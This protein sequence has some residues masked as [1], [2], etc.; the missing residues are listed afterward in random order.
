MTMSHDNFGNAEDQLA[1]D[2]LRFERARER[3]RGIM[4]E[5]L[6]HAPLRLF[7]TAD[8]QHLPKRLLGR[9]VTELLM[10]MTAAEILEI[11]GVGPTR[12]R[13]LLDVIERAILHM[14]TSRESRSVHQ[15]PRLIAEPT[16]AMATPVQPEAAPGDNRSTWQTY[17]DLI[18][19]HRLDH[20]PIG[21][22][23]DS[24][25]DLPR[26]LWDKPL[27]AFHD[28]IPLGP[29]TR[30]KVELVVT[31]LARFLESLDPNSFA[32]LPAL[33]VMRQLAAWIERAA[34]QPEPPTR[35]E[36]VGG[37]CEPLLSQI[38]VDSSADVS[39]MCALKLG[40][41]AEPETLESIG[42]RFGVTRERIRQHLATVCD[43][44][45]IRWPDGPSQL[46]RL[47]D[48]LNAPSTRSDV[49]ELV[50]RVAKE[51]FDTA[52]ISH[53]KVAETVTEAWRA[54]GRQRLTPMTVEEMQEWSARTLPEIEHDG[55]V[56]LIQSRFPTCERDRKPVW[57]SDSD[58]D[59]VLWVL[60]M[61]AEPA[62]VTDILGELHTA[63]A[64]LHDGATVEQLLATAHEAKTPRS[65]AGKMG[66]DPRFV[67]IED[68]QW[69]PAEACGF[70][71]TNGVWSIRLSTPPHIT[72]P[73]DS[74]PIS[75]V[76]TFL[77]NG[78]LQ[79]GIVDATSAGVHRFINEI[80][81]QL[82]G[83][84][85]PP[86]ITPYVL[87]DMLVVHGDGVIRHMRRR[88]LQWEA[89]APGLQA[90]G[91][92]RWVG[93]V[94]T[95]VGK[96]IVL[97]E[98]DTGLRTYYQ[99]YADYVIQQIHYHHYSI[100]DDAG[101]SD[102]RV[103]FITHLGAGIPIIVAPIDWQ[104]DGDANPPNVSPGVMEVV[105]QLRAKIAAGEMNPSALRLTSWLA[106]LVHRDA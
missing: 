41:R 34:R 70:F 55:A 101:G 63:H 12:L 91:K 94:V 31:Q 84:S 76:V 21:M 54:A 35:V 27:S 22:F 57:F 47:L 73:L 3:L 72:R 68:K 45:R 69:L 24:I 104:L 48:V 58:T 97:A 49:Q 50:G 29:V 64:V 40:I 37:F 17:F 82:F 53:A 79:L 46:K 81:G 25:R 77:V 1:F 105:L 32:T 65:L 30:Q 38:E 96:P 87:A 67:E 4:G 56:E 93:H 85:L 89:A 92:R 15:E 90:W 28:P 23:A 86:L 11:P 62:S 98:L 26:G 33:P 102:K 51:L 5:E 83:A 59:K 43:G 66:R 6:S 39:M 16:A 74:L 18:C 52:Q 99:D 44:L 71:Q 10:Q 106:E 78:M 2:K 100:D 14:E 7:V 36:F 60:H 61:R 95:E 9:S 19:G 20:L 103:A 13:R 88:R 80:L 42:A 75:Q 8:D